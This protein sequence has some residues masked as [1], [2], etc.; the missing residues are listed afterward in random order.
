MT[1][2]QRIIAATVH[3]GLPPL[4]Y[5][6]TASPEFLV[7]PAQ[8]PS[9]TKMIRTTTPTIASEQ[10][11]DATQS[12]YN[13]GGPKSRAVEEQPYL[14]AVRFYLKMVSQSPRLD[15]TERQMALAT[16][17]EDLS[18][19]S[20]SGRIRDDRLA[21]Q[22]RGLSNVAALHA[23]RAAETTRSAALRRQWGW[24]PVAA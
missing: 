22:K 5:D 12:A 23:A 13:Y 24:A 10:V 19:M 20:A 18:P 21:A 9:G 14:A 4:R 6:P 16:R 7:A 11:A 8:P 17:A 15:T 2:S 3:D 1:P